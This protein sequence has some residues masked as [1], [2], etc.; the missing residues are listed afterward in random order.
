MPAG[1]TIVNDGNVVQI[2]ENF[3]NLALYSKQVVN[4]STTF[5][6]SQPG[7]AVYT[8]TATVPAGTPHV[9]AIAATAGVAL[10]PQTTAGSLSL[11]ARA[12]IQ[13]T[14]YVFAAPPAAA[15]SGVGLQVFNAAGEPVFDA[16]LP[17]M[18]VAAAVQV[19]NRVNGNDVPYS[20]TGLPAGTYA[21]VAS[22]S[23]EYAVMTFVPGLAE[24][25][26]RF[27]DYFTTTSTGFSVS[28]LPIFIAPGQGNANYAV[29]NFWALTGSTVLLVDVAGL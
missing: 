15:G 5:Q 16:A 27:R 19:P 8:G 26:V 10:G 2:D 7:G 29:E 18:R 3:R 24:T 6:N 13:A 1:L 28:N 14:V 20:Y 11:Y 4:I 9:V 12:Q 21:V 25:L 22:H 23:R 17:Y